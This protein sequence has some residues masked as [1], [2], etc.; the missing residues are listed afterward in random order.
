MPHYVYILTNHNRKLLYVGMATDMQ[1]RSNEHKR[2]AKMGYAARYNID[3]LI[4]IEELTSCELAAAR[5][6][7]LKGWRREK[8]ILL[9]EDKNPAWEELTFPTHKTYNGQIHYNY[10]LDKDP[11]AT[12][13][14]NS[15]L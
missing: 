3:K 6:K 5:E 4:Y 2:K 12:L 13:G 9:V 15:K 11:S 14:I 8:K 1:K 10:P 7:Q